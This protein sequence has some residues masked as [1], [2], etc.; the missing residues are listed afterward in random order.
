LSAS[1]IA[2]VGSGISGLA[3][4][5]VLSN[6]C[7]VVV[8]EQDHRFGGHAHTVDVAEPDGARVP[9]DTGFIV[10]N[11]ACYPNLIALFDHL[12]VPTAP[13]KMSF[14][15]SLNDGGY[16]YSGSARGL[17]GQPSNVLKLA[18]W[19]LVRDT[20]RF[21]R[22]AD[23]L[24]GLSHDPSQSLRDWLNARGYSRA[25]ITRHIQP[26][27]AAIWSTPA[28]EVLDFP[29]AAFAR[30][31]QN[32]GLL[33]VKNRPQWRTVEGGSRAYVRRIVDRLVGRGAAVRAGQRV[34]RVVRRAGR[35]DVVTG[36]GQRETFDRVILACHAD[37]A[38]A[39]LD[40]PTADERSI[41]S[42]FRYARNETYL[43]RDRALMPT[44]RRLWS[45]WNYIGRDADAALCVSYHMNTL[46]P[47]KTARDYIVTLNPIR[48][49]APD[50][51]DG[52]WTY[53]HPIFDAEAMSAQREIGRIQG[54]G[55]VYFAGAYM[56]FGFHECGLQAG[57]AAAEAA[58]GPSVRRPW[59]VAGE[60]D[61]L[62]YLHAGNVRSTD[63]EVAA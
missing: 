6:H 29:A 56:G 40:Q 28:R 31:F 21:F 62:T 32:H 27:A 61:R 11:T 41:L 60:S 2:V 23:E 5:W 47:L 17:L 53:T 57:L 26:M 45:S 8:F 42:R 63:V 48:P 14:A 3:A 49:I 33:Q 7:R 46:Q 51:I 35:V 30:F 38:L 18:H 34:M 19:Q 44:R 37:Q 50:L 15:V 22:E 59:T 24:V 13:T 52:Q 9:I 12:A 1:S 20:L 25:F 4:A 43:H 10:Y 16:E 54:A 58:G 36:D 39:M 55:S